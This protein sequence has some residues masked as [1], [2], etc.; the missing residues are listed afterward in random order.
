VIGVKLLHHRQKHLEM[1]GAKLSQWQQEYGDINGKELE[2]TKPH[3][4]TT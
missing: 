4:R 2:N 3:I 1:N